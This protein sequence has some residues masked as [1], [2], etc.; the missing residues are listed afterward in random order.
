M[1][2]IVLYF[3]RRENL[4]CMVCAS[5]LNTF[6]LM[7]YFGYEKN[8]IFSIFLCILSV[9]SL[10][11]HWKVCS[12]RTQCL[13]DVHVRNCACIHVYGSSHNIRHDEYNH[14]ATWRTDAGIHVRTPWSTSVWFRKDVCATKNV[15]MLL[16]VLWFWWARGRSFKRQQPRQQEP[17]LFRL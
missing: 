9:L 7:T 8:N 17:Q 16:F 6:W 5:T 15:V 12:T 10:C 4:M 2:N 3:Q 14:D 1:I 13:L 11:A